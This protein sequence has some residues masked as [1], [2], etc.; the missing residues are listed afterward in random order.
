MTS[1]LII[2][3]VFLL[4]A[5]AFL[6]FRIAV[7]VD[8]VKG[9]EKKY[10]TEGNKIHGVLFVLFLVVGFGSMFWY[11]YTYFE[12][13]TLPIASEHGEATDTLFWVTMAVTG[14]IFVLTHVLLFVF[15]FTFSHKKK[16]KALFYPEN[17]K[18]E[19][20]NI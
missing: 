6:I 9:T 16:G 1:I 3:G 18:L 20:Y 17:N 8:V 11:S 12:E 19:L 15:P 5:V 10:V 4:L 13:Y 7:L 2:I 14:F